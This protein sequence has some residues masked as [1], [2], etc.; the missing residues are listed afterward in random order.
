MLLLAVPDFVCSHKTLA[1]NRPLRLVVLAVSATGGAQTP[2]YLLSYAQSVRAYSYYL[3]TGA[4]QT[5]K[6]KL[7]AYAFGIS[8]L[9]LLPVLGLNQRHQICCHAPSCGS[10]FCMLAKTACTKSTATPCRSRCIKKALHKQSNRHFS[11]L[12]FISHLET[13]IFREE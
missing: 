8:S 6:K 1:Q 7:R 11:L 12:S 5:V 9:V 4:D 13:T 2:S 10:R 3:V